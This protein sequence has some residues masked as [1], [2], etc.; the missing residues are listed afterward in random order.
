MVGRSSIVTI[1]T[2]GNLTE[3]RD[4][5]QASSWSLSYGK[6]NRL[7]SVGL[8]PVE[9]DA[10]GNLL[11]YSDGEKMG[12]YEYDARNRLTRSGKANY[13]YDWKGNESP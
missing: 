1:D 8:Y 11:Y 5:Q 10:D 2:G 7:S 9:L 13:R 3:T 4:S 12:A 6:D